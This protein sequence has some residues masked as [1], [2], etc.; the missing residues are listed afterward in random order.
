MAIAQYEVPNGD[1]EE[2]D[3]FN[4]WNLS[5]AEW[6][7]PNMQ[8]LAPVE[9][10]S[11]A[12][13]GNFAM[14]VTPLL[15]FETS[16]AT[17]QTS[18][19]INEIPEEFSFRVKSFI[20]EGE[21]DSIRVSLSFVESE[22]AQSVLYSVAWTATTSIDDWTLVSLPLDTEV[23]GVSM[24]RIDVRCGYN[25]ALG[26]GPWNSWISVDDMKFGASTGVHFEDSCL[27]PFDLTLAGD[28]ITTQGCGVKGQEMSME[29]FD[30][31]GKIL[32]KNR[33]VS[34]GI[35]EFA[36]GIYLVRAYSAGVPVVTEKFVLR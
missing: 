1:F 20:E 27:K 24:I 32:A 21:T 33:G 31:S 4:T 28:Q 5:P 7:T 30:L 15:G 3:Y 25:G 29:I 13:E 36:E 9:I 34:I 8:L 14:R 17:A 19:L 6:M 22:D 2:W 26:G 35:D 11:N 12:Y 23:L 16:S 10:D 18:F